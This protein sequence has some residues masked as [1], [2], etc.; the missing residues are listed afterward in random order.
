MT[1]L[2]RELSAEVAFTSLALFNILRG[3]LEGIT[4][5]LINVLQA[6]VSLKRI[7]SFLQ[8]EETA[9]YSVIRAPSGH[10]DPVVGFK[11]GTFT[12]ADEK[13]AKDDLSIFRIKDLNLSFPLEQLSLILGPGTPS[14]L[15]SAT[16]C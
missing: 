9:K 6:H 5:M 11:D 3:P 8:E 14:T 1:D 4:D 2:Q 10:D 12:W 13:V 15:P 16:I 7:D